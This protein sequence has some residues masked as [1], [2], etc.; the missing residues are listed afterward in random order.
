MRNV[1]SRMK[2]E[3]HAPGTA[4]KKHKQSEQH[5]R[6]QKKKEKHDNAERTP[7]DK[8]KR[9]IHGREGTK[10]NSN[11]KRTQRNGNGRASTRGHAK[12]RNNNHGGTRVQKT[13]RY[14]NE[15]ILVRPGISP[16]K[17]M[18]S[19]TAKK[20]TRK[21]RD[22]T[23]RPSSMQL[24]FARFVSNARPGRGPRAVRG[25]RPARQK[26]AK[27]SKNLAKF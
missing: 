15:K 5:A 17:K 22:G 20:G 6:D 26:L 8:N 1:R 24:V 9:V 14:V 7:H 12:K 3:T 27:V 18:R 21:L 19:W 2:K 23:P 11:A 10:K 13:A 16:P 25:A 4:T